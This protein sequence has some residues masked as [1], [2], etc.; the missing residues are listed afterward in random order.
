MARVSA[1]QIHRGDVGGLNCRWFAPLEHWVG[2]RRV[3]FLSGCVWEATGGGQRP[4]ALA[5]VFSRRGWSVL[6]SNWSVSGRR[7]AGG[8]LVLSRD[9]LKEIVSVL[10]HTQGLVVC[11]LPSP[12]FLDVALELQRSSWCLLHDTIDDWGA[13]NSG[14]EAE[15]F[16][17]DLERTFAERAD[18]LTASAPVLTQKIE[19]ISGRP[20]ELVRNA[21]PSSAIPP[22]PV[23]ADM[24]LGEEGTVV[25][26]GYLYGHWFD[27]PLLEQTVRDLPKVAFNVVGQHDRLTLPKFPN[28]HFIGER[29][30]PVAMQYV[31]HAQASII[32]FKGAALSAAVDPIKYYDAMSGGVPTVATACMTDL[33]G[34]E[35]VVL[36]LPNAR[37][38]GPAIRRALKMGRWSTEQVSEWL[39]HNCWAARAD[40]MMSLYDEWLLDHAAA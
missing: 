34:R 31:Y 27:W 21:G 36:T 39:D 12:L 20:V 32:P 37:S 24:H 17:P 13:F 9:D 29:P 18:I 2:S 4:V 40:R 35:N 1:V 26:L 15:W 30:Y 11:G 38:M 33:R 16:T 23:P 10:R 3:L 5:R 22:C 28:L 25:Y 19:R 14:G 8:P 6:Y 7:W